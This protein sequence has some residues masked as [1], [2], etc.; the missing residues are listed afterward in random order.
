MAREPKKSLQSRQE[1]SIETTDQ[2]FVSDQRDER[3]ILI[4]VLLKG[5]VELKN[6]VPT[7]TRYWKDKS[8]DE[9]MGREA[10]AELLRSGRPLTRDL[11]DTLAA[12]FDPRKNHYPGGERRLKFEDRH[13]GNRPKTILHSLV[14]QYIYDAVKSGAGV[15]DAIEGAV[16]KFELEERMIKRIWG[17][18]RPTLE[19]FDG[20]LPPAPRGR[21]KS[22]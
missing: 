19:H 1:I 17:R 3:E 20:A 9:K 2:V 4:G 13:R 18:R 10:L 21:R 22:R 7:I 12:L 8:A 16:G 6:D 5:Y 14:A 11:R 15:G